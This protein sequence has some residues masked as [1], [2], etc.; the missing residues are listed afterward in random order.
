MKNLLITFCLMFFSG[1]GCIL[2]Q[3]K[4]QSIY[5]GATCTAVLPDY[6]LKIVA[7]DNCEI[8]S[9]TQVPAPGFA[10]TPTLKTTTVT[11]KATDGT[12][13]FRQVVFTVTLLD[14]IKPVLTIDPSLLAYQMKQVNDIYD[15]GDRLIAQESENL[16]AQSWIDSIPGLRD[17]LGDSTYYKKQMLTWTTAGKAVT[18]TGSR[19]FT[20]ISNSDTLLIR[21]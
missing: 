15:F 12:G 9:L 6:R 8:A 19:V 10:L 20:W 1:C 7:T 11:V 2:S 17:K 5:A 14:T 3:V 21:R 18:G 16:M 4:S 13:N